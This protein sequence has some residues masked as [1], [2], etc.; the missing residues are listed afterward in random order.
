MKWEAHRPGA[1]DE[2][3]EVQLAV[4]RL[5]F[6][7]RHDLGEER[8]LDS[9]STSFVNFDCAAFR[10][11]DASCPIALTAALEEAEALVEAGLAL[12]V[13]T[14]DTGLLTLSGKV[15]STDGGEDSA[16]RG[17]VKLSDRAAHRKQWHN[18]PRFFS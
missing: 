4:G 15:R 13:N 1:L 11:A 18:T 6:E 5:G 10:A 14:S 9:A 12:T 17:L 7:V 16:S 2:L 8:H 3:V